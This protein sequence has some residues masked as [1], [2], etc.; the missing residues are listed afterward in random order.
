MQKFITRKV[1]YTCITFMQMGE[2]GQMTQGSETVEGVAMNKSQARRYLVKN[3]ITSEDTI[4]LDV[5][6]TE[7][8]MRCPMAAF[9]ANST[10]TE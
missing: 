5:K 8:S 7:V 2:D 10:I 1:P 9:I 4:I 6:I 3:K